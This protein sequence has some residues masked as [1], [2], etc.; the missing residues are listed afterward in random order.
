M[1][2][3]ITFNGV[4]TP[5]ETVIFFEGEKEQILPELHTVLLWYDILDEGEQWFVIQA[6]T[7]NFESY[8]NNQLCLL[9]L[10]KESDLFLTSRYFS[11][12]YNISSGEPIKDLNL[13]ELPVKGVFFNS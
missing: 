11:D 3:L 7:E 5:I 8:L 12:Y 2:N 4:D 1:S 9:S 6:S 13:F 10:M